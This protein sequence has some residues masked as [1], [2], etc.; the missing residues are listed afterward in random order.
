MHLPSPTQILILDVLY[1][2][3][4]FTLFPLPGQHCLHPYWN[5]TPLIWGSYSSLRT[6]FAFTSSRKLSWPSAVLALVLL[7]F[8][9]NGV[10]YICHPHH[11]G[12]SLKT[13]TIH[14]FTSAFPVLHRIWKITDQQM[15][16]QWVP[17]SRRVPNL[18]DLLSV[19]LWWGWCNNNRNKIHNKGY[20]LESSQNHLQPCSLE[21]LSSTKLV[22]GTREV[23]DHCQRR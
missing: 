3:V 16:E 9:S 4:F 15:F 14:F 7:G 8:H 22:Q 23:W 12:N 13:R 21:K 19:D 2:C 10:L 5:L 11:T 18:Q 20:V 1:F 6:Q 17:K